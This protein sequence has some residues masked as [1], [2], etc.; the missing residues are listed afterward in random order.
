ML[1]EDVGICKAEKDG[2]WQQEDCCNSSE[3]SSISVLT[4]GTMLLF[5]SEEGKRVLILLI[6]QISTSDLQFQLLTVTA[7]IHGPN[8]NKMNFSII[9]NVQCTIS[10]LC[11]PRMSTPAET[12]P[13][14]FSFFRTVICACVTFFDLYRIH[15]PPKGIGL[16]QQQQKKTQLIELTERLIKINCL[17]NKMPH[18]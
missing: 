2:K 1:V 14:D 11:Q 10:L 13:G 7:I 15:I 17:P 9:H 8:S 5:V 3:S 6:A 16:E 4:L 18:L 12:N